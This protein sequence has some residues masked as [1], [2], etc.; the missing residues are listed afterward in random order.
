MWLWLG[1]TGPSFEISY[2]GAMCRWVWERDVESGGR[3]EDFWSLNC[4]DL[5]PGVAGSHD[6]SLMEIKSLRAWRQLTKRI[7]GGEREF[8]WHLYPWYCLCPW[9]SHIWVIWA[10]DSPILPK[11]VFVVCLLLINSQSWL[12]NNYVSTSRSYK[13]EGKRMN[14]KCRTSDRLG[15]KPDA[16]MPRFIICVTLDMRLGLSG[17][18]F[19]HSQIGKNKTIKPLLNLKDGDWHFFSFPII[20]TQKLCLKANLLS[21]YYIFIFSYFLKFLILN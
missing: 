21:P 9:T 7:R 20:S 18:L 19:P 12:R 2:D 4:E 1:Q 16:L 17:P 6:F 11:L 3:E 8:Q 5:S 10:L 15:F 13:A 14:S